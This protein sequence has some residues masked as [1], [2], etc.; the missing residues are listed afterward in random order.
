MSHVDNIATHGEKFELEVIRVMCKR[1]GWTFLEG[2]KTYKWF[3][4]SIG[5]YPIPEGMTVEDLGKCDHAIQVPGCRYEV[6]VRLN[7]DGSASITADFW[8]GGGL[9]A[10]LGQKGEVFWQEYNCQKAINTAEANNWEWEFVPA[11]VAGAKKI[12][13]GLGGW[14]GGW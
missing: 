7:T 14:G 8:D 11:T 13:V 4:T 3:G 2:Q 10:V 5:D 6:G 12:R 9:N 1:M